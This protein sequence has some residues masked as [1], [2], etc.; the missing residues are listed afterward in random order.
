MALGTLPPA[1]VVVR[2]V[3]LHPI[4]TIDEL[5]HSAQHYMGHEHHVAVEVHAL[6]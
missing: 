3:D 1:L 2:R 4:V 6:I 5:A